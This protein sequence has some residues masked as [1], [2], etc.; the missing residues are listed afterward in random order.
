VPQLEAHAQQIITAVRQGQ[1]GSAFGFAPKLLRGQLEAAVRSSFASGINELLYITGA[2]ALVGA[3]S[4]LLLIRSRDFA[5][6][7]PAEA[8][9]R[10][11]RQPVPG[12]A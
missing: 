10:T 8:P 2:L 4:S 9:A 12:P 1:T 7:Q 3:I 5:P 6:R 11:T